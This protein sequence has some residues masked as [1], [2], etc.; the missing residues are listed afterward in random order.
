MNIRIK[1]KISLYII[2]QILFGFLFLC[3][4]SQLLNR[5]IKLGDHPYRYN[6]FSLNSEGD[7]IVD[8][9][10]YPFTYARKFFGIKKNGKEY[11][12]FDGSKNYHI[13]RF[14][15]YAEG[16]L[17]GESNFIKIKS[18]ITSLNGKEFI[19]GISK[20][21]YELAKTELYNL[22]DGY[23]LY[24][25]TREIF[26]N[27]TS[28]V[29]SIIPDPLNTDNQFNYFISFIVRQ[30]DSK[31]KL[32]TKKV[33]YYINSDSDKGFVQEDLN[34]IDAAIQTIISCFF[35]DNYLY[36]CFFT[37]QDFNLTISVF[38][39]LKKTTYMTNIL[40]FSYLYVRRFYKGIHFK[41]EIGFF[42]YFIDNENRPTF[43]LYQTGKNETMEVYKSYGEIKATQGDYYNAD[44][45]N[46]LIKFNNNTV[47]FAS[48]SED[49]KTLN[50]LVFSFY[51]DDNNMNVRYFFIKLWEEYKIKLFCDIKICMFNNF[52]SLAFSHCPQEIC[53]EQ[54]YNYEHLSSLI[55]FNYPNSS[56]IEFDVIKN[57][58]P[59]KKDIQNDI[60]IN[61]EGNL[62]IENNLFG[63][64][65]KGTKIINY[66]DEID[67]TKDRIK[68]EFGTILDIGETIKLTFKSYNF[69]REGNF[70]IE[71]AYVLTEPDYGT[72]N[73]NMTYFDHSIGNN[74]TDEEQYFQKYDYVGKYSDFI[75]ILSQNLTTECVKDACSLCNEENI[76]ITCRYDFD[77]NNDTNTKTCYDLEK[78][79]TETTETS[80]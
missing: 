39:P 53:S 75:V 61:F 22:K 60:Y 63:Y 80:K 78:E 43:S 49:K 74:I 44:L 73:D 10:P 30:S 72:N 55:F 77:Y 37:N 8:T 21:E 19:L 4:N 6:H 27:I 38:D 42:A 32:N 50:I 41:K 11:F 40:T 12:K 71:F 18:N 7:L 29:F 64:I 45:L 2:F 46:D 70:S 35:T 25:K 65:S 67:I 54:Y 69:Y 26:G 56:N 17:E 52:L 20:S 14:M 15:S 33:F 34:Q 24:Y 9:E 13:S 79:I 51:N 66:P 16:R 68:I 5:I 36:I 3:S 47:C 23:I 28:N 48:S 58:Y 59:D 57:I 1:P 76:C 62:F 31:Y